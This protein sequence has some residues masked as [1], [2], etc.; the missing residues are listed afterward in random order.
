MTSV[1]VEEKV[2]ESSVCVC[3]CWGHGC[4]HPGVL[5]G[6]CADGKGVTV[7]RNKCA[8]CH[9]GFTSFIVGL[10]KFLSQTYSL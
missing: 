1:C 5:C 10:G 4:I 6:S 2:S 3:V 9:D 8:T 7:L